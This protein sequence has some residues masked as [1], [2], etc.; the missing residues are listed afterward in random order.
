MTQKSAEVK[1]IYAQRDEQVKAIAE[2]ECTVQELED[3]QDDA[4]QYRDRLARD[5]ADVEKQIATKEKDLKSILP[6]LIAI[7]DR[8]TKTKQRFGLQ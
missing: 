4:G 3:D 5:L 1:T 8:E 6:R 2:L 7:K